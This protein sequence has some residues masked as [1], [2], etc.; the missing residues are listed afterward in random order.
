MNTP[1]RAGPRLAATAPPAS[2]L[3]AFLLAPLANGD[4]ASP[5]PSPLELEL[6]AP[7]SGE[8]VRLLVP[9]VEVRGRAGRAPLF[10]SDVVLAID[11]SNSTLLASGLDVDGDGRVGRTR[12]W[13]K[14]G[15][16]Y[17]EPPRSWTSDPGDTVLAAELA[18]TRALVGGLALRGSR[19][20]VL[21]F[22]DA[23]RVRAPVGAPAA[24][25]DAVAK[26]RPIEDWTGTNLARA[27]QTADAMLAAAAAPSGV[28]RPRAILL[29]SDGRPSA[30]DRKY[31]ASRR[32]LQVAGELAARGVRIWTVA[33]GEDSDPEYLARL[34][35]AGGGD[36]IALAELRA[37][38]S[39]PGRPRLEAQSLVIENRTTGSLARAVRSF[40]DGRFDGIL[41]LAEGENV[42]EVRA[43]L[44]D[45][46]SASAR[47]VV[48]YER[49]ET[50]TEED[51]RNVARWLVE[52][53]ERT[54]Q[55]D[56]R[57]SPS[58]VDRERS[59]G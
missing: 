42:V 19:I 26:I 16:G 30:P 46:R 34:A 18:T 39:E 23:S 21:T 33:F 27:L 15:G 5:V 37:L 53:R 47:R 4:D 10:D 13:A 35:Q 25:G 22:T 14:D 24:A 8:R 50:V 54:R 9:L 36:R 29:F 7:R 31:W 3:L 12:R 59:G 56:G 52:L 38:A 1:I 20:G 28:D 48:H 49:P 11:Q 58:Q 51:R 41:E 6:A 57:E 45:G 44:A 2:L 40:A 55:I 32:A 17:G 43:V